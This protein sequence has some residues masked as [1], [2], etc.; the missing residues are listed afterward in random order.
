MRKIQFHFQK[1]FLF[2]MVSTFFILAPIDPLLAVENTSEIDDISLSDLLNLEVSVATKTKMKESEAPSIVSVIT[3][4]EIENM[5]AKTVYDVLR[6]IP[7]F[8]ITHRVDQATHD[9]NVRGTKPI[10]KVMLM[11]NGHTITGSILYGGVNLLFDKLPVANIKHIEIIRGPGSALYGAGAFIGVVN[12]VTKEGG[13]TPSKVAYQGG[14][15]S[16]SHPYGEFSYKNE[17]FKAYVYVDYFDTEGDDQEIE[18]DI[19]SI[20]TIPGVTPPTPMFGSSAPG[21]MTNS[22]EYSTIQTVINYKR[23][24]FNAYFIDSEFECPIGVAK[25]LT[26]EDD[27]ERMHAACDIKY[28]HP[29]S[30]KGNV[31]FKTFI[32]YN[33]VEQGYELWPE[34]TGAYHYLL[35][36][37]MFGMPPATSFPAGESP[38]IFVPL[39]EKNYGAEITTDYEL[40]SGVD[41]IAGI[42]YTQS[43]I[44]EAG[45]ETNFNNT[46]KL[47]TI[48]GIPYYPFPYV[49]YHTGMTDV[50]DAGGAWMIEDH[51][52]RTV[53]A[54]YGQSVFDLKELFSLEEGVESL[55]LT[56]GIRYDDYDDVGSTT[57]PRLGVVYAPTR[58]LHFKVLYGEAFRAPSF[59]ELYL[60]DNSQWTG[61]PNLDPET[62][63]TIEWLIGYNF[64]KNIKGSLTCFNIKI[65]DI[66]QLTPSTGIDNYEN[67]GELETNGAEVEFKFI[68]D[69]QKY[70]Y[71]NATFQ[72]S[73]NTTH[74]MILSSTGTAYTHGDYNPGSIPDFYCNI[75]INYD[76][77]RYLIANMGINYVGERDRNEKYSWVTVGTTEI[78]SKDERDPVD[79]RTLLSASLTIRNLVEGM[80]I[81]LSGFN[82]LDE[83][84]RDPEAEG[85]IPNDMPQPEINF[86]AK[87]SYEF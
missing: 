40:F 28:E 39:E 5:G 33:D 21:E 29:I 66:I 7:G 73:K 61:N 80:K 64:T 77:N 48:G 10:N 57:N 35:Y 30:E 3:R 24:T 9:I 44:T 2:I 81:Q 70:A 71:I 54:I 45:L 65:E 87:V 38:S 69:E 84:H 43:E 47:M 22:T 53:S 51:P 13:D 78:L 12:I 32:D 17:D 85:V 72:D 14:S 26:D 11:K 19:A 1:M 46:G 49:Y 63:T 60:A 4:K 31:T 16:T 18:A 82:L 55:T 75:G 8:D 34:E 86:M 67:S 58:K 23:L 36:T 15:Y 52:D 50:W 6:T 27:I 83:D 76:I 20:V 25:A 56:A 42:S 62:I 68:F 41:I 59:D 74:E 37:G 79:A